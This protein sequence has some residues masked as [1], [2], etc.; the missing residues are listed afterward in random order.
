MRP[1]RTAR[2]KT[3]QLRHD[4]IRTDREAWR[5]VE[6]SFVRLRLKRLSRLNLGDLDKG[7]P[8]TIAFW[9]SVT[10]PEMVPV[11]CCAYAAE[12]QKNERNSVRGPKHGISLTL[13]GESQPTC[14]V[15]EAYPV[16][17]YYVLCQDFDRTSEI[18]DVL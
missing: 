3:F 8:P 18:S 1:D 2:L 7:G 15:S 17:P 5:R 12:Q 13:D 14:E 10:M 11:P 4:F 6:A 9:L 16:P